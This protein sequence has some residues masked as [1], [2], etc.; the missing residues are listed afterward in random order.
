MG[1]LLFNMFLSDLFISIENN[2][3]T[4]YAE[5]TTLSVITNNLEEVISEFKD[6]TEK[7]FIWFSQKDM[8]ANLGKCYMIL[9]TNK[10]LNFQISETVIKNS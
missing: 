8:K 2:Y 3:F 5:D 4:S 6:I 10:L 7:L 9:R 1:P